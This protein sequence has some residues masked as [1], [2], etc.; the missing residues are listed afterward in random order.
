MTNDKQ[1]RVYSL[2]T[3][4][5]YR[6]KMTL[7]RNQEREVVFKE[8]Q[9]IDDNMQR[10][11]DAAKAGRTLSD[12][13]GST[14]HINDEIQQAYQIVYERANELYQNNPLVQNYFQLL[15]TN[16][17]G[18]DGLV[19]KARTTSKIGGTYKPNVRNNDLM[20]LH[21]KRWS[22]RGVCEISGRHS[23]QSL[24]GLI[25][26]SA[27]RD[28]DAFVRL[29]TFKP[30]KKNPYGL[31][32]QLIAAKRVDVGHN[33]AR[34]AQGVAIVMGIEVD[35]NDLAIAY[36]LNHMNSGV[37][38]RKPVQ[39]E[40]VLAEDMYHVYSQ[41]H[42]EQLR[43]ISWLHPVMLS[44]HQLQ[45][46]EDCTAVA[47]R[48]GASKMG[49]FLRKDD[50]ADPADGLSDG[51][52]DD[53]E[54]YSQAEPGQFQILPKGWDFKEFSPDFP[55]ASHDSYVEARLK[56][57]SAG[58]RLGNTTLFM[59]VEGVNYS[60]I[61]QDRI[62]AQEMFKTLHS[63][64]KESL[65]EPV[66][67]EFVRQAFKNN[68]LVDSTKYRIPDSEIDNML[69]DYSFQGR[70]WQWVDPKKDLEAMKIAKE[71]C[72]YSP[73]KLAEM[74]GEDIYVQMLDTAA[75]RDEA[76]RLNIYM[77]KVNDPGVNAERKDAKEALEA[78]A[79]AVAATAKASADAKQATE[80]EAA[81]QDDSMAEDNANE[82]AKA[83]AADANKRDILELKTMLAELLTRSL[84]PVVAVAEI[85]PVAEVSEV[86][87]QVP[88]EPTQ[89]PVV[90]EV[91]EV[92]PAELVNTATRELE[93]AIEAIDAT[94]TEFENVP[95]EDVAEVVADV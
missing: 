82:A 32:L 31:A 2:P 70:S 34:N 81:A 44:L 1:E 37:Q 13:I 54:Y 61:R 46:F 22:K 56:S 24:L 80:D 47:A 18:P 5:P 68:A 15:E 55:A 84:V 11:Y 17:V 52:A 93:E 27:A 43:G 62:A 94:L 28:G 65:L 25:V 87:T 38:S 50:D 90:E 14:G 21:F 35:G 83:F 79:A 95:A 76:V 23:L 29:H 39:R 26:T 36:H 67:E 4:A 63:W 60:S 66:Y 59:K 74:M 89:A 91:G 78:Q 51:V 16:I 12:W 88:V 86:S 30:T 9:R 85:A 6:K 33:V 71:L 53:G 69:A 49:F 48:I 20:E 10:G 92:A 45:K 57:I 41:E 7:P 73:A 75:V 3:Q 77:D 64:L 72:I 40:R 8:L 42:A 19:F 58:L